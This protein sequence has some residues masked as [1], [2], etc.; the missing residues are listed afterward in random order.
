M[1]FEQA[2]REEMLTISAFEGRVYPLKSLKANAD[3][4]IPYLIYQSSDGLREKAFD[5]YK[6]SKEVPAELN[7]IARTY[8]ELKP[9]Q[10]EAVELLISMEQ[11]IIG[12]SGPFI[13]EL[14]YET[15]VEIYEPAPKLYRC[16]IDF[17][18]YFT[19]GV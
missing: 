14:T 10:R 4:G 11:R 15:P 1:T 18:V 3:E 16:N 19:E 7:I 2:L 6:K 9:I 8:E 13:Q 12:T 5:G 17:K